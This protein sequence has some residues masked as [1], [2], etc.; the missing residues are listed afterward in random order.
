MQVTCV[1]NFLI[2]C[3]WAIKSVK[4][5]ADQFPKMQDDKLNFIII[6][7]FVLSDHQSKTQRY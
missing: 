3:F 2:C 6:K 1:Y 4:K 5:Y 7:C